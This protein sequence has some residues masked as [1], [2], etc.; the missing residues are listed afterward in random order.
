V[1]SAIQIGGAQLRDRDGVIRLVNANL[2]L[3]R[4]LGDK[5]WRRS[6]RVDR[7][8]ARQAGLMGLA[9]AAQ[10]WDPSRGSLSTYAWHWTRHAVS[11]LARC[12]ARSV[13]HVTDD[14]DVP[15]IAAPASA[16]PDAA[17]SG[18]EL[19]G[20][21][22]A[23]LRRLDPAGRRIVEALV[24]GEPASSVG[25]TVRGPH[26]YAATK[27]RTLEKLRALL[28]EEPRREPPEDVRTR[29]AEVN[30]A[31]RARRHAAKEA[32]GLPIRPRGRPRKGAP[33]AAV[34]SA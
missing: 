21:L 18:R 29:R 31:V 14:G 13:G 17:I 8:D 6:P 3:A 33:A 19:A 12:E 32:A 10:D 26:G 28:A 27:A 23:C 11:K 22:A 25:L 5:L 7:D 30:A 15:E 1:N 9:R 4:H 20:R 2:P 24:A 34:A 16:R